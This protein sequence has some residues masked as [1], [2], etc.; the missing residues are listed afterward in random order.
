MSTPRTSAPR[1]ASGIAVVPSPQP[2]SS[3][4]V[5]A[6]MPI[7]STSSAPASRIEPAMR[8]KS[9]FSHSA[10]FGVAAPGAWT[11]RPV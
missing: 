11:I 8:V 7:R 5:P 1:S 6:R 2:R 4:R 3:T 9:P 10:R